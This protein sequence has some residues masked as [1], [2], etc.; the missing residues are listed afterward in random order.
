MKKTYNKPLIEVVDCD[1]L[2]DIQV[3]VGSPNPS[4][5]LYNK[6][7]ATDYEEGDEYSDDNLENL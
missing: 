3:I 7:N 2:N 1:I 5:K 6:N 4:P